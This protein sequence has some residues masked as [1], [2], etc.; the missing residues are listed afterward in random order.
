MINTDLE[1]IIKL[2][3][4]YHDFLVLGDSVVV[5]NSIP[6]NIFFQITKIKV[7]LI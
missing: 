7:L 5:D 2:G 4:K 6:I 3:K 1:I